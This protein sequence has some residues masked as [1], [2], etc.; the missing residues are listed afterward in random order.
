MTLVIV[1]GFEPLAYRLGVL[2]L[3]MPVVVPRVHLCA[4]ITRFFHVFECRYVRLKSAIFIRNPV[5]I[6]ADF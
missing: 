4:E 2:A 5:W 3:N 6:L 1:S